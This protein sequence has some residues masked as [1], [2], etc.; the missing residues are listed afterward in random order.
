MCEVEDGVREECNS[1]DGKR[2]A[3]DA[4]RNQILQALCAVVRSSN[5]P[6]RILLG[7]FYEEEQRWVGRQLSH[8]PPVRS[9]WAQKVREYLHR[10]RGQMGG[11]EEAPAGKTQLSGIKE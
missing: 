1:R 6:L 10:L 7:G 11:A 3:G 5:L 4:S 2:V 9:R 8:S